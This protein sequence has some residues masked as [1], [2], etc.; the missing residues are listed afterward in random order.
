MADRAGP[1]T[2]RPGAPWPGTH[3][4]KQYAARD[5]ACREWVERIYGSLISQRERLMAETAFCAGWSARK[6]ADLAIAKSFRETLDRHRAPVATMFPTEAE[7]EG[8]N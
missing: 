4:P 3:E 7:L 2:P 6:A 1:P 8:R 5:A